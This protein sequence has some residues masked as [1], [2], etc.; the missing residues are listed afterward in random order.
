MLFDIRGRR[1]RFV[2]VIY[3]GLALLI[4]L[5]AILFG[6]GGSAN[7]GLADLLGFGD[8]SSSNGSLDAEAQAQIDKATEALKSNPDDAKALLLLVR[9]HF[10]AGNAAY[11]TDDS[12]N[13]VPTDDTITQY[14][15][16][17]DAWG[18][19][20]ATDPKEPD[21]KVAAVVRQA[22]QFVLPTTTIDQVKPVLADAEQT[23]QIYADDQPSALAYLELASYAYLNGDTETGDAA[24]KK[25]LAEA[26]DDSTKA[27]IQAQLK[28]AEKQ[29]EKLPKQIKAAQKATTPTQDQLQDP[30][31]GLSGGSTL[32]G[33]TG[34]AGG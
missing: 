13:R 14:R 24:A 34:P 11:G 26:P 27:Q 18:K 29:G 5:G 22:Y 17:T 21:P 31:G 23:S 1:K 15:E 8:S 20:L 30:L 12:G 19:Y 16:A 3:G 7:G 25:A 6:I 9:G 28:A 4:G 32:P 33:A 10:S 2:Q